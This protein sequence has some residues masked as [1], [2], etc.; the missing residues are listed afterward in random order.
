MDIDVN[1]ISVLLAELGV[2]AGGTASPG[3]HG[4]GG[5]VST[6]PARAAPGLEL[7]AGALPVRQ[8]WGVGRV[9]SRLFQ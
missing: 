1:R 5:G 9:S 8:L 4:L 6:P 3:P 2:S 7:R